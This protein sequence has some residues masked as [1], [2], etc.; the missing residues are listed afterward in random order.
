M[1][2]HQLACSL[3]CCDKS[4]KTF[5]MTLTWLSK[6]GQEKKKKSAQAPWWKLQG[7]YQSFKHI[8]ED[9]TEEKKKMWQFIV[10]VFLFLCFHPNQSDHYVASFS[11]W[12]I[13][14]LDAH[15]FSMLSL[16]PWT[17][18]DILA[19]AV[20]D[21]HVFPRRSSWWAA[22]FLKGNNSWT[23]LIYCA[24]SCTWRLVRGWWLGKIITAV[25]VP[26]PKKMHPDK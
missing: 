18:S 4:K 3:M 7:F 20:T 12:S 9:V 6:V 5:C 25:V 15:F 23:G 11:C 24:T 10:R 16:S 26:P 13:T 8:F 21:V 1:T 14:V 2:L 19:H 22:K 17:A